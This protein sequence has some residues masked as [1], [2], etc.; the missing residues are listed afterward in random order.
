MKKILYISIFIFFLNTNFIFAEAPP[1]PG[2]PNGNPNAS[3]TDQV[4]LNIINGDDDI[5]NEQIE[6]NEETIDVI[7]NSATT[8]D[9]VNEDTS[10]TSTDQINLYIINSDDD[11][12]NPIFR[13]WVEISEE[14]IDVVDNTSATRSISRNNVLGA[15]AF[16]DSSNDHFEVTD[17][18]YSLVLGFYVNCITTN[19]EELCNGPK[20]N[21]QFVVNDEY[22]S[23]SMDNY[24]LED[25]DTVYIYF[26]Q[27]KRLVTPETVVV[28]ENF[29]I[30]AQEYNY[31]NGDWDTLL[32]DYTIGFLQDNQDKPWS[33]DVI[34]TSTIS[35]GRTTF[36]LDSEGTYKVG[37]EVDKIYYTQTHEFEVVATSTSDDNGNSDGSDN[38]NGNSGGGN[39]N[40]ESLFD[41]EA[42]IDFLISSQDEDGGYGADLYTDWSAI[43]L[44]SVVA[45]NG[46]LKR[47]V[48]DSSVGSNLYDVLRK[49]MA[50]MS[51]GLDP[52]EDYE[53]NL[54]EKI[55]DEYNEDDEDDEDDEDSGGQFG[56]PGFFNDDVFALIVLQKFGFNED[57][58]RISNSIDFILNEQSSNG[59]WEGV[60]LTAATIQALYEFDNYEEVSS[61]ISSAEDYLRD[62]QDPDG[63]WSDVYAT[64]WTMMAM[65]A[66][67]DD[68]DSWDGDPMEYLG[69]LQAEDGGLLE[70]DTDGNRVWSTAYAVAAASEK[71]WIEILDNFSLIGEDN[72][73]T[74]DVDEENESNTSGGGGNDFLS[75]NDDLSEGDESEGFNDQLEGEEINSSISGRFVNNLDQILSFLDQGE[76]VNNQFTSTQSEDNN[77]QEED[78]GIEFINTLE[79]IEDRTS[80]QNNQ[81]SASQNNQKNQ[82]NDNSQTASVLDALD[83]SGWVYLLSGIMAL[84]ISVIMF[85]RNKI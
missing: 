47:N 6:I 13:E 2:N 1:S 26:G 74:N 75:E 65:S 32:S 3:S 39:S 53:Q 11:I 17:M 80:N 10:A 30:K 18:S 4:E 60:D 8:K 59:S 5:F 62:K 9:S 20:G 85:R 19:S 27:P 78:N 36:S 12:D 43:A 46:D 45:V 35:G 82:N 73:D 77:V 72:N 49:S 7:D 48:E 64:A 29:D 52:Q 58:E 70:D 38:G 44:S 28:N 76:Q 25:D 69:D 71:T 81:E 79:S 31:K 67:G 56:D 57:D 14:T 41:I 42:A 63:G 84:V 50:L 40:N 37:F 61:S 51:L 68:F 34:A 22:A 15:L 24:S 55:L 16:T 33:P 66:L 83:F 21:W 54:I 23:V